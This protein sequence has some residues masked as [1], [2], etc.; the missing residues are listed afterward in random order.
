MGY[1]SFGLRS[2]V[3]IGPA[4]SFSWEPPPSWLPT[5]LP[6]LPATSPS[7]ATAIPT[8]PPSTRGVD[9]ASLVCTP[10]P[11]SDRMWH[12]I[13]IALLGFHEYGDSL[14]GVVG[15]R[16]TGIGADGISEADGYRYAHKWDRTVDPASTGRPAGATSVTT[17]N[18]LSL[19]GNVSDEIVVMVNGRPNVWPPPATRNFWVGKGHLNE[20]ELGM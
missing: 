1:G 3:R 9:S 16:G 6:V 4:I 10:Q 19:E 14:Y 13:D 2:G 5:A 17:G 18:I 8:T 7:K 11:T 15:Y 12:R 20:Y